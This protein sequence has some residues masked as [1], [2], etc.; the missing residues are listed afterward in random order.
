M[1]CTVVS[2]KRWPHGLEGCWVPEHGP[3]AASSPIAQAAGSTEG[4]TSLSN[5]CTLLCNVCVQ[6]RVRRTGSSRGGLVG[7]PE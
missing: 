6:R 2:G 4:N 5:P 7:F 3:G 1:L